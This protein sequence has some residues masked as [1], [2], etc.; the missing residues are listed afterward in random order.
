MKIWEGKLNRKSNSSQ[1]DKVLFN[2]SLISKARISLR[3]KN[4]HLS[5]KNVLFSN[6]SNTYRNE[7]ELCGC[8]PRSRNEIFL[9]NA[10]AKH[11]KEKEQ[12]LKQI[13][14]IRK[15]LVSEKVSLYHN[16]HLN[17]PFETDRE[18]YENIKNKMISINKH[19]YKYF[20][21]NKKSSSVSL[22][23]ITSNTEIIRNPTYANYNYNNSQSN[24]LNKRVRSL[25]NFPLESKEYKFQVL[26]KRIHGLNDDNKKKQIFLRQNIIINKK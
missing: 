21:Q 3:K 16:L 25:K 8:L 26:M 19:S 11:R 14:Q 18:F 7:N 15:I 23:G 5:C 22:P 2:K 24:I 17:N 13:N 10:L 9:D 6:S 1:K 20:L 4:I 12:E